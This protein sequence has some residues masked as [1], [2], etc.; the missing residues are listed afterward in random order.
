[1]VVEPETL[2]PDAEDGFVVCDGAVV[3]ALVVGVPEVPE[4]EFEVD[5]LVPDGELGDALT[6]PALEEPPEL[7]RAPLPVAPVPADPNPSPLRKSCHQD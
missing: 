2:V 5:V 3:P 7:G 1:V 6:V 4:V